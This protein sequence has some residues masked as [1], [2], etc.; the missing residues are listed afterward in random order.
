MPHLKDTVTIS[1]SCMRT[2]D[3]MSKLLPTV[4]PPP[5]S[6]G[7]QPKTLPPRSRTEAITVVLDGCHTL[8]D[9][10][11]RILK[12]LGQILARRDPT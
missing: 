3:A 5:A 8:G 10:V 12:T 1:S 4:P 7:G 6:V 11:E 2:N 9:D